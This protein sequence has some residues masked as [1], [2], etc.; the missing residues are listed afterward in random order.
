MGF[1]PA[2]KLTIV[3]VPDGVGIEHFQM[4]PSSPEP[5][6]VSS[7]LMVVESIRIGSMLK[8]TPPLACWE[9]QCVIIRNDCK[10]A[11]T[12]GREDTHGEAKVQYLRKWRVVGSFSSA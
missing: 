10:I 3:G 11:S 9:R 4:P 1:I 7:F 12:H 5:W 2:C 6:N 8:R